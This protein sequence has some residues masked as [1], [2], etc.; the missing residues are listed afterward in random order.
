MKP[1]KTN[2]RVMPACHKFALHIISLGHNCSII[3]FFD[4]ITF[5]MVGFSFSFRIE[6]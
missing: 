3:N 1:S 5:Y 4:K 6:W 2:F